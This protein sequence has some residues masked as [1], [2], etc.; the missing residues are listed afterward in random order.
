METPQQYVE[1]RVFAQERTNRHGTTHEV[2][3]RLSP[4]T[5]GSRI[6]ATYQTREEAV[7]HR[8]RLRAEH[9]QKLTRSRT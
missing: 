5:T 8:D 7:A 3:D 4:A 9:V 6:V 2:V 1:F